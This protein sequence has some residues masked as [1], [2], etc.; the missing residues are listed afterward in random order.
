MSHSVE[1]GNLIERNILNA[2]WLSLKRVVGIKIRNLYIGAEPCDLVAHL[3]AKAGNNGHAQ[4]H[5]RQPQSNTG[6]RN[7]NY[8]AREGLPVPAAES[9]AFCYEKFRFQFRIVL[10]KCSRKRT[11]KGYVCNDKY[12][13]NEI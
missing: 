5:H 11:R 7:A 13:L 12:F 3:V 2:D 9:D 6:N 10:R 8:R 4:N 1:C